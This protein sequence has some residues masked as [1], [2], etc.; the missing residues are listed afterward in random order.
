MPRWIESKAFVL[1]SRPLGERDKLC[2]FFTHREGKIRAVAKGARRLQSRFGA[3]LEPLS[4]VHLWYGEREGRELVTLRQCELIESIFDVGGTP[5]GEE[6]IH[7]MVE[8]VDEFCPP[9]QPND[10]V[11][12]L[13][14]AALS[15]LR[16]LR[17][18]QAE[19]LRLYFDVWMLRLSG[20]F[21][22]VDRC[23]ACEGRISGEEPVFLGLEGRPECAACQSTGRGIILSP[24]MRRDLRALLSEP[25][26]QWIA[27]TGMEIWVSQF[28]SFLRR[29]ISVVLEKELNTERFR[30]FS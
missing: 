6:L 7:H 24:L 20:F 1:H 13:L 4:E 15:C 25:P 16:T 21:P 17:G 30:G 3:S 12:R 26:E 29:F 10:K 28:M 14:R 22:S 9:H 19:L 23:A 8:L 18:R 11:Y 5:E 2:S 27:R